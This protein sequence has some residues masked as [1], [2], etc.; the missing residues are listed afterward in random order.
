MATLRQATTDDALAVAR[1]H[2]RSWQVGYRGLIADDLLDEMNAP[3]RASR[4]HFDDESPRS[5]RTLVAVDDELVLGFVTWGP[6]NDHDASGDEIHALYVDPDPWGR[7]VGTL[8]LEGATTILRDGRSDQLHLWVLE[9]NT[10]AER[11]YRAR[12]WTFD[13]ASRREV[14]WGV[15]VLANRFSRRL[16]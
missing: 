5:P 14:V 16:D 10:R 12:G 8:L 3:E 9:G 11:F 2:V 1:V 6:S 7:G 13:G 4:Y 15:E